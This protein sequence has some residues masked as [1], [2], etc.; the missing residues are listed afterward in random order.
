[1]WESHT[2]NSLRI[3]FFHF[4]SSN[5]FPLLNAFHFRTEFTCL[6]FPQTKC[7]KTFVIQYKGATFDKIKGL[8]TVGVWFFFTA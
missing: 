8:G 2:T 5:Y 4:T 1:M 7:L 3:G 6:Y